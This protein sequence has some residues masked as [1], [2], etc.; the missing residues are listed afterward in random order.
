MKH[1]LILFALFLSCLPNLLSAQQAGF[2]DPG[3]G[4]EGI[5][6]QDYFFIYRQDASTIQPDGKILVSGAKVVNPLSPDPEAQRELDA[7]VVRLNQDG[8]LDSTFGLAGFVNTPT[9]V[10]AGIMALQSNGKI[11]V[12]YG[13]GTENQI[14][15]Y[16]SDG[17]VDSSFGVEGSA[18]IPA[19]LFMALL[20]Q[21]DTKIIFAGANN[22]SE[23][24]VG[25]LNANG[26]PDLSFGMGGVSVIAPYNESFQRFM[27]VAIQPDGKI[28]LATIESSPGFSSSEA[29]LMRFNSDGSRDI[30]FGE[31]GNLNIPTTRDVSLACLFVRDT[32]KIILSLG[33]RMIQYNSGGTLDSSFSGDGEVNFTSNIV[34]LTEKSDGSLLV[35]RGGGSAGPAHLSQLN[36]SGSPDTTFGNGGLIELTAGSPGFPWGVHMQRDDR[37]IV[38][39]GTNSPT[40][41]RTVITRH[42]VRTG[43]RA[44]LRMPY[45][46]TGSVRNGYLDFTA[47]FQ[48]IGPNPATQVTM[49]VTVP[50]GLTLGR[51]TGGGASCSLSSAMAEEN[52]YT[53]SLW[54]MPVG[55]S[56]NVAFRG[57]VTTGSWPVS[58][59]VQAAEFDPNTANNSR[60]NTFTAR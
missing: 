33:P 42:F 35:V 15:R 20:I 17:T 29:H 52:V 30:S 8:T 32:G 37:I 39:M 36:S 2:L 4:A 44:D 34:D 13:R 11:L 6:T 7:A 50:S 51:W 9:Y 54:N 3:F 1:F 23:F 45:A 49:R 56:R 46:L 26:T 31:N 57:P 48:N 38:V 22:T 5:F 10:E 27:K 47:H 14:T 53:C 41:R 12:H 21:P 43:P 55:V 25:R 19:R 16:H 60:L 40:D 24:I 18:I 59:A 28:I 58:V